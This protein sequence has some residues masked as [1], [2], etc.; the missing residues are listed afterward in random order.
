M[1]TETVHEI[2]LNYTK[3]PNG[4]PTLA[5]PAAVQVKHGHKLRF[6]RGSVPPDNKIVILF[7]EP[8]LFSRSVFDEG[9]S[10]I[11][12]SADLPH[13][14]FYQ[15]ALRAADGHIIPE[16]LTGPSG[17]GQLD[18]VTDSTGN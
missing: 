4:Q 5:Q 2:I 10:D 1:P 9:H 3:G 16:S 7:T 13:S 15:C 17:G 11:T 6:K 12:V 8:H 14:T 18:P